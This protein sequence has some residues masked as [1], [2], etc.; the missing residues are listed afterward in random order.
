M[1]SNL[2][3]DLVIEITKYLNIIDII[4]LNNSLKL[5]YFYNL[6]T[7]K[8]NII[9]KWYRKYKKIRYTRYM[10]YYKEYQSR[11][12]YI[13]TTRY[14]QMFFSLYDIPKLKK[15]MKEYHFYSLFDYYYR[16]ED[17]NDIFNLYEH[18]ITHPTYYNLKKFL[19][20]IKIEIL[21]RL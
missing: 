19:R 4:H 16:N 2:P 3:E 5:K 6:Y 17:N 18:T 7:P 11:N 12:D 20:I 21:R 15:R 9:Q 13:H 8:A 10:I 14:A 1:I